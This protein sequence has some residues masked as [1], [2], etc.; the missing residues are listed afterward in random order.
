MPICCRNEAIRPSG[1]AFTHPD[2]SGLSGAEL[3][4]YRLIWER[5]VACQMADAR[6]TSIRVDLKVDHDNKEHVFRA[7]GNRIDFCNLWWIW[8]QPSGDHAGVGRI[9]IVQ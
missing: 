3:K 2:K 4:L 9:Y 5:T 6:R 1:D 8:S 7:N